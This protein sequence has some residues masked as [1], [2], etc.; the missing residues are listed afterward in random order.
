MKKD[1]EI[2]KQ[3]LEG[4]TPSTCEAGVSPLQTSSL[5]QHALKAGWQIKKLGEV[6][7]KR[8]SKKWKD[9]NN[10][11]IYQYIDLSSVDR[12]SKTITE[13]QEITK[14]TAPSRAQQIVNFGD[15]L[16]G[17]TRPTLKRFCLVPQEYDEQICSTGFCIIRANHALVFPKWAFYQFFNE[18]FYKYIEPLQKGANYP[19]V[20][21]KDIMSFSIP[22]PPLE[23]QKRIVAVLDK[24]FAQIE[25]LKTAAEKNLQNTKQIFQAE[26]EKAFSNISWEKKRIDSISENHDSE[27]V[28]ITKNVRTAGKYPYYG[29]SGIVDYVNDYIFEGKYLL[30]SEDGANLL[31]RTY[32]IAFVAEGK[33]WVNN[34]AHILKFENE[35]T[36]RMVEYYFMQLDLSD[37]V[38]GMAQPKFNQ[39]SLNKLEIPLPPLEEQKRIVAHLDSLS[40]KVHQLEEIYTKQLADCDELKQ[41][42]LQKAFEGEL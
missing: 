33:F 7:L 30:V 32:P 15:V 11:T 4:S 13:I 36:M 29:A 20:T 21:D 37:Y 24:K 42:L 5:P 6:C 17:T 14:K 2:K 41:S 35:E 28:P 9:E 22:V 18:K 23:E 31:A 8:Q 12:D 26:L 3:N 10:E 39:A 19:A 16:F 27:R 25:T 1:W 40:E 34:H 38:T